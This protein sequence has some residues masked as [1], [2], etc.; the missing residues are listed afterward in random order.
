MKYL[1]TISFL[2]L[3]FN[4]HIDAMQSQLRQ[5]KKTPVTK[6]PPQKKIKL[7]TVNSNNFLK[8]N[9]NS[10]PINNSP[11]STNQINLQQQESTTTNIKENSNSGALATAAAGAAVVCATAWGICQCCLKRKK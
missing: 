4:F 1:L 7:A 11:V 2:M 8:S 5:R 10:N 9:Y 6:A 3:G